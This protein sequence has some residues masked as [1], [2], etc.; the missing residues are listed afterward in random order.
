M[1]IIKYWKS[2][3]INYY[4]CSNR[5][6]NY[7]LICSEILFQTKKMIWENL[8]SRLYLFLYYLHTDYN[9]NHIY[10]FV[11]YYKCSNTIVI[12]N[13]T[14]TNTNTTNTRK[15][16]FWPW[17]HSWNSSICSICVIFANA[18]TRM[19]KNERRSPLV[20][21]STSQCDK[22]SHVLVLV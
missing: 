22:C 2:I 19:L 9:L 17:L 5:N 4:S 6:R 1:I 16:N 14:N 15:Q 21:I 18:R 13:N 11:R 10:L 3:R 8:R 12:N 20:C 7:T